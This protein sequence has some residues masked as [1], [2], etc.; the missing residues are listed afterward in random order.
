VRAILFIAIAMVYFPAHAD[1]SSS[2]S[3]A[4]APTIETSIARPS[5]FHLFTANCKVEKEEGIEL[6]TTPQSPPLDVDDPGTPGCNKWEVNFTVDGDVTHEQRSWEVPLLDINYGIGDNL[7]IAYEIP[8]VMTLSSEGQANAVGRSK[9]GLKF[10]FYGDEESTL[11]VA[12]YPQ[13]EFTTQSASTEDEGTVT[14]IPVLISR[15]VGKT[16]RGD[17]NL[18]ANMA[19]KVSSN[20]HIANAM[21]ASVGLGLPLVRTTSLLGDVVA[22]QGLYNDNDG[23]RSQ[24]IKVDLGV[25][26]P[27]NKSFL[28]YGSVGKSLAASDGLD[29]TYVL[30]GLRLLSD[31]F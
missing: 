9:A 5:H 8:S 1:E 27:I 4:H 12:L 29:H 20:P 19:Y 11:Q 25:I 13:M 30:A 6:E 18:S 2:N 3:T 17:V 21:S 23:T 28:A 15:T 31:G 10:Q 16:S 14:S 22:E 7:Q 24:L 26:G